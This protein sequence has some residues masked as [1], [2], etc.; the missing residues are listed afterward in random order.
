MTC[1]LVGPH[2]FI[3]EKLRQHYGLATKYVT[4][5]R[6]DQLKKLARAGLLTHPG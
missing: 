4:V 5:E 2:N 3:M 6:T 1:S